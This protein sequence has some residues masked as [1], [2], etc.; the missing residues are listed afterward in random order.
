MMTTHKSAFCT[1]IA[2]TQHWFPT[3][4]TSIPSSVI[5]IEDQGMLWMGKMLKLLLLHLLLTHAHSQWQSQTS[6][7]LFKEKEKGHNTYKGLGESKYKSERAKETEKEKTCENW[8][9]CV[10]KQLCFIDEFECKSKRVIWKRGFGRDSDWVWSWMRILDRESLKG[11]AW[12]WPVGIFV[13][14]VFLIF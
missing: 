8:W 3:A 13:G 12:V 7:N 1:T 5:L 14:W 10:E 6:S 11:L 4:E 9:F 2:G